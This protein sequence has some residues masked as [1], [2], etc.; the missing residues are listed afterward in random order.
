MPL[1]IT[2][3]PFQFAPALPLPTDEDYA[4][5]CEFCRETAAETIALSCRAP[6]CVP[7][8]GVNFDRI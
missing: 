4:K 1:T 6:V 2:N 3:P 5:M 7:K 8:E